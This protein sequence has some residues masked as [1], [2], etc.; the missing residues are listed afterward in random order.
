MLSAKEKKMMV[1]MEASIAR[2]ANMPCPEYLFTCIRCQDTYHVDHLEYPVTEC[3]V[4]GWKSKS[5]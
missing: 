1:D 3:P 5:E 4:C 2:T